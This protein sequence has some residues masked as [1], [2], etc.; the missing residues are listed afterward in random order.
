MDRFIQLHLLTA[1]PPANLNRDDLNRPKSTIFGGHPR[2]RVSSQS[3][4]RAWR[5][6]EVFQETL[7]GHM[8]QRT[9][10]IGYQAYQKLVERGVKPGDARLWAWQIARQFGRSKTTEERDVREAADDLQAKELDALLQTEQL[11]HVGADELRA[12]DNLTATLAGRGSD[13]TEEELELLRE[14]PGAVDIALFGRMLAANP[15]FNQEAAAQVAHAISVNAVQVEDDFFTAVDDLN[16][17]TED[18]GAGH[19]GEVEFGAGVFY[20]Y[21]CVDRHLLIGNLSDDEDLA[22]RSL[23]ALVRAAATVAPRGKQ[24]TFAS[25]A[26]ASYVMAESGNQQPRSLADAYLDPVRANPFLENSIK[27]LEERVSKMDSVY[28]PCADRRAS[29][30]TVAGTGSMEEILRFVAE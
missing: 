4:K 9:K 28:G 10:R 30:N 18:V 6:S 19:M 24:A 3:L 7:S 20:L 5:T 15:A 23:R 8:G 26:Y 22:K 13:P 12:I 27:A 29:L 1:Y 25:R 17:G 11:V 16:P 2:L 21:V 14:K